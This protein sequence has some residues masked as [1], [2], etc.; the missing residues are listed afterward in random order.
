MLQHCDQITHRHLNQIFSFLLPPRHPTITFLKEVLTDQLSLH[1]LQ[2]L[3]ASFR[4]YSL[5]VNG[6]TRLSFAG[7]FILTS[8]PFSTKYFTTSTASFQAAWIIITVS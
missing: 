7:T 8:A 4:P 2:L 5:N 6:L 1:S 3:V